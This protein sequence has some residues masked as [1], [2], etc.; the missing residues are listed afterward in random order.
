MEDR[1]AMFQLE[2]VADDIYAL[3]KDQYGCRFFQKKL[4]E[5]QKPEHRD[6]IFRQIYSHFVELMTDPFGNYLCQKMMEYCT[7]SQRTLIVEQVAKA[8]IPISL[9][10]HGT[11]AVQR[12]IEFLTLPEQ[13]NKTIEAL[14]PNVVTLIKDINGNHVVQKCLHK[15][16]HHNKQFIYDSV[17]RYCIEVATHRHGCC[18]LQR[19][20]DYSADHQKKQLVDVIIQHA[21]TLVQDP[22]G[23]YVVQY[24][25]EL[26]D[27]QFSDQLIRQFL[28]HIA[29]LSVQKYSSNVIEKCIRVAEEDTRRQL[30]DE[31]VV[32]KPRL[33]KLLKDSFANY[34]VQTA[35]DFADD[36]QYQK[37][38]DCIRPL[39]PSIRN[40]AYCKRIQSKLQNRDHQTN[41]FSNVQHSNHIHHHHHH[42]QQQQQQQHPLLLLQQQHV[43]QPSPFAM[44]NN[45]P[46]NHLTLNNYMLTS[47]NGNNNP[48]HLQH[49]TLYTDAAGMITG[50]SAATHVPLQASVEQHTGTIGA[51]ATAVH[52]LMNSND[53]DFVSATPFHLPQQQ[54]HQHHQ[55]YQFSPFF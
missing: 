14:A 29:E 12:M 43:L 21:L 5:R 23:N 27:A 52:P 9:N 1:F 42:H 6:I 49:P 10:M 25:L 55:Q 17:S 4:E 30:I 47:S 26:G 28:N 16:S 31:M 7:D 46:L 34:V 19:C 39:L 11:R 44:T 3:C 36:L 51:S 33:E 37:L 54:Q 15:L 41:K 13:I 53:I 8:I 45:S 24:V 22:Y 40:T 32:D 50:A 48:H 35:L 18:V 2:D 20:I 38:V